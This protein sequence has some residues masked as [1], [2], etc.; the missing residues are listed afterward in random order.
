MASHVTPSFNGIKQ[1][2]V[3][4]FRM[5]PADSEGIVASKSDT[6]PRVSKWCD[7]WRIATSFGL[8]LAR[9]VKQSVPQHWKILFRLK[10][11][12]N[13]WPSALTYPDNHTMYLV[14]AFVAEL[15]TADESSR[16]N[17]PLCPKGGPTH[18]VS[19]LNSRYFDLLHQSN[20]SPVLTHTAPSTYGGFFKYSRSSKFG[21]V[22]WRRGAWLDKF[23]HTGTKVSWLSRLNKT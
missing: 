15:A 18:L 4:R 7:A 13:S 3:H 22:R 21:G 5:I 11:P 9:S 20:N 23:H 2:L 17:G 8:H 1:P 6:S 14:G 16:C 10:C 19:D 12:S